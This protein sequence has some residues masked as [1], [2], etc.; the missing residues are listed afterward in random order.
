[1]S[2]ANGL[3]Y[4]FQLKVESQSGDDTTTFTKFLLHRCQSEF[5][6]DYLVDIAH[7]DRLKEI[8]DAPEV[9]DVGYINRCWNL[10]IWFLCMAE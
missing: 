9:S 4:L 10:R 3:M 6:K 7:E 5:Q 2:G 1:M 8:E